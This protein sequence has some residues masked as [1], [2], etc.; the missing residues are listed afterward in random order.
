MGDM[1]ESFQPSDDRLSIEANQIVGL[2][3]SGK[4]AMYA[5]PEDFE[6][7]MPVLVFPGCRVLAK[8]F[9]RGKQKMTWSPSSEFQLQPVLLKGRERQGEEDDVRPPYHSVDYE[10]TQRTPTVWLKS[11][12]TIHRKNGFVATISGS[13][14]V[15]GPDGLFALKTISADHVMLSFPGGEV[16]I[17]M[18]EVSNVSFGQPE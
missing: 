11:P 2:W 18:K 14:Y 12:K 7:N 17:P 15:F 6:S 3:P 9:T 13:R 1:G 8:D 16:R 10:D 5:N 4:P